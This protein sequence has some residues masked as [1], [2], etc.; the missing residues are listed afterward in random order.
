MN[1]TV[2]RTCALGAFAAGLA[3][4]AAPEKAPEPAAPTFG[5]K[6]AGFET[7]PD[8]QR[9]CAL[10][11]D[12]TMHANPQ[13]F[14]FFHEERSPAGGKRSFC[15]EP[16]TNEPWALVTQGIHKPSFAGATVRFSIAVRVEGASGGAG[17]WLLIQVPA[18]RNIHHQK[19][20]TGTQGWQRVMLQVDV[21]ADAQIIELGGTLEGGGRACFDDAR[22]ELVT[23][24]KNPV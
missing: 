3:A 17:P 10:G 18:G 16:L 8:P 4:C 14:R 20:V 6:N 1:S 2:V 7:A 21:P 12:C 5:L 9:P 13:A 24:S 22:I 15:I 23:G 11:W 19:L